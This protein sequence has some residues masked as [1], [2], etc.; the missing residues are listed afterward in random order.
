MHLFFRH[1]LQHSWV[2]RH[3]EAVLYFGFIGIVFVSS[4]FS[5]LYWGFNFIGSMLLIVFT[6]AV[7]IG[8]IKLIVVG[9]DI[10]TDGKNDGE[11]VEWA[12][13]LLLGLAGVLLLA[14]ALDGIFD[15]PNNFRILAEE[16]KE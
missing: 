7:F 6:L 5:Y 10:F 2:G 13:G 9:Y 1:I 4:L 12:F 11:I 16:L 15:F 3:I 14:F 8:S